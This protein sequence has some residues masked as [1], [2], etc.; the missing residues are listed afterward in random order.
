MVVEYLRADL[1]KKTAPGVTKSIVDVIWPLERFVQKKVFC[2]R[3]LQPHDRCTRIAYQGETRV[4]G[5]VPTSLQG[6]SQTPLNKGERVVVCVRVHD[7]QESKV[8][9]QNLLRAVRRSTR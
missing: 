3:L 8:A 2:V 5:V 7:D 6:P 4:G 9:E 1:R